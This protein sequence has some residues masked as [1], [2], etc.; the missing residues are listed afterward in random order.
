[1]RHFFQTLKRSS[2]EL[3]WMI[4]FSFLT[5]FALAM[6]RPFPVIEAIK[7]GRII[8][9][10]D[11]ENVIIPDP[12]PGVIPGIFLASY[13]MRTHAPE[14]IMKGGGERERGWVSKDN[15][16]GRIY[17]HLYPVDSLWDT[18]GTL[19]DVL[20]KDRGGVYLY[21]IPNGEKLGLVSVSA[22]P[23]RAMETTS[24][25]A[26][27]DLVIATK[28]RVMSAIVKKEAHAER[29]VALYK[30][31]YTELEN[32]LGVKTFTER[33]RVMWMLSS[34]N[35]W[36]WLVA[37][38]VGEDRLELP[39]VTAERLAMGRGQEAER[40]LLIN[41]DII[42][43]SGDRESFLRDPRWR[44]MKAVQDNKVYQR[45]Y[46]LS[47]YTF[48][49]DSQPMGT[50]WLA[51]VI[52][53]NRIKPRLREVVRAHYSESYGYVMSDAE[54]D[55]LLL[56]KENGDAVGYPRFFNEKRTK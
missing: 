28:T 21:G 35:N 5:L 32:E 31:E 50:R 11:G 47:G 2:R 36:S 20:A 41:P 9:N 25:D 33:P 52:F 10:G 7:T 15:I 18:P 53:P 48:H 40:L 39:D 12:L 55:E 13:L 46:H 3:L 51:E 49:I 29:L 56:L 6:A 14:H 37:G 17:P 54:L 43:L 42:I 8:R 45:S 38:G 4:P 19:E 30:R 1:M 27:K 26:W 22:F 16:L 34:A 44:G 24:G 23:G